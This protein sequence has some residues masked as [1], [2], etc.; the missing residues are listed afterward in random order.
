MPLQARQGQMIVVET[1]SQVVEVVGTQ[2]LTLKHL[3][4]PHAWRSTKNNNGS[5]SLVHALFVGNIHSL[6]TYVFCSRYS[7]AVGA[8]I[9]S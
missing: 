5:L 8:R 6:K 7:I 3:V 4:R 9:S 2:Q 1:M